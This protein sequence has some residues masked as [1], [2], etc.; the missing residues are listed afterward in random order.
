MLRPM[1][2]TSSSAPVVP[3]AA[4]GMARSSQPQV[5]KQRRGTTSPATRSSISEPTQ[6]DTATREPAIVSN[7][8]A[9]HTLESATIDSTVEDG[10]DEEASDVS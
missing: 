6:V 2:A 1:G 10:D 7:T 8:T 5:K 9:E 4:S 3:G